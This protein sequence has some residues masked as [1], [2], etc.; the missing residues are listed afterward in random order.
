MMNQNFAQFFWLIFVKRSLIVSMAKRELASQYIGSFFGLFWTFINPMVT[1]FVFWV[2]FSVGFKVQPVNDVPF[3]VWLAAGMSIWFCFADIVNGATGVVVTYAQLIKKTFFPARILP[4]VKCLSGLFTHGVFLLVLLG[5]IAFQRMPFNLFWF[6][7]L[8]YLFCML[9]LALGIG[10]LLAAL[11]VFVRDTSHIV[12]VVLQLGF[13]GTPI[14]WDLTMMPDKFQIIF[15][16]NP[17][18]YIVQGYRE[19]FIYFEPFWHHPLQTLYF[20]IIAL[21]MFVCGAVVFR[22]LRPQF[23]DVL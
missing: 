17:M 14:F 5:L 15:K 21:L 4:V 6:Q 2:I 7:S 20:W 1:I 23:A 10:W 12:S 9:F 16:L 13:W 3:V 18:Y 11:Q 8:Y 22:K 19:S